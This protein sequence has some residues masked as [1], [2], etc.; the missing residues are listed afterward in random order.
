[1]DDEVTNAAPSATDRVTR[2][3]ERRIRVS[4]YATFA[5]LAA[6]LWYLPP[7]IGRSGGVWTGSPVTLATVVLTLVVAMAMWRGSLVAAWLAGFVGAWYVWSALYMVVAVMTGKAVE[8]RWGPSI[9]I[10]H[11]IFGVFGFFW[12]RGGIA[13]LRLAIARQQ[14]AA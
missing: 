12:V 7:I 13:A 10:A 2:R 3:R 8:M 4:A 5:Y 6:Q 11:L 1:V 14:P 9:V